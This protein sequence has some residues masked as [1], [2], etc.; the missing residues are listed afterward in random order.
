MGKRIIQANCQRRGKAS[1]T[2][3]TVTEG[4]LIEIKKWRQNTAGNKN[5]TDQSQ[6]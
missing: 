4:V 3:Q 6:L 1:L 5:N 2:T